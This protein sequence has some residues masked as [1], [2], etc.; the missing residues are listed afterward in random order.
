VV[1]LAAAFRANWAEMD[2]PG[3][4][5]VVAVHTNVAP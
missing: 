5:A 3:C 1:E 2:G 4:R